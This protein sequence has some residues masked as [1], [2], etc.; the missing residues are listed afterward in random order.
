MLAYPFEKRRNLTGQ[1]YCLTLRA[2]GLFGRHGWS[3]D[4]CTPL[5]SVNADRLI[6]MSA[7]HAALTAQ[8]L[9]GESPAWA[10][11]RTDNAPVAF[12]ILGARFSRQRRQVPAPELMEAVDADLD[13][14]RD[15]GFDLPQSA[16][17]YV[18]S[19]LA[20]GYLV[21]RPGEAREELYE[22]SDGALTALR[23]IEDLATPRTSVTESRLTTIVQRVR[24][25]NV[26]TDPDIS[27]RVAALTAERDAID[28]RGSGTLPES[29]QGVGTAPFPGVATAH[30][31][32]AG[33]RGPGRL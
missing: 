6:D 31:G 9:L 21:R 8:R 2:K 26:D 19:W 15:R 24:A 1:R 3:Y 5:T 22:L 7:V 18:R 29:W 12:G 17:N 33:I 14:L 25:L 11:L 23:F 4:T 16:Q 30:A 28:A 32:A 13:L 20:G 10:L 27:Q